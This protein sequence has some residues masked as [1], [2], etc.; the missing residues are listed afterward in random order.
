MVRRARSDGARG[1]F[2]VPTNHKAPYFMCLKQRSVGRS[3]IV[4]AAGAFQY[5][6]RQMPQHTLFAVDFGGPGAERAAP[7][8][9]Q[10]YRRRTCGRE[11]RR[12]DEQE[13]T[14]ITEKLS[15]LAESLLARCARVRARACIAA[16]SQ[17]AGGA[18][19]AVRPAVAAGRPAGPAATGPPPASRRRQLRRRSPPSDRLL[20]RV[21]RQ[22]LQRRA[23]KRPSLR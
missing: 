12:I 7:A 20:R 21:S 23:S 4:G 14:A 10:E 11:F 13:Q 22:G 1:I 17:T 2:L 19:V 18:L 8:C 15:E 9:G 5:T 6:D 3:V 16:R